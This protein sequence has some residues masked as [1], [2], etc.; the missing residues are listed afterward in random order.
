MPRKKPNTSQVQIKSDSIRALPV[1][2]SVAA[3]IEKAKES[4][5]ALTASH[6]YEARRRAGGSRDGRKATPNGASKPNGAPKTPISSGFAPP[7]VARRGGASPNRA[8]ELLKALAA[9]LGLER[10]R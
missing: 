1:D 8:E 10:I 5:I 7:S 6:V 4:G 3:V 2:L 9:D